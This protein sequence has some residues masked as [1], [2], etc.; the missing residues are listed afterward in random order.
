[1]D[2]AF[3]LSAFEGPLDLLL[4]LIEQNK[5][6][7]YDIPISMITDQY[8][9]YLAEMDKHDAEVT[10][11]FLV[12]AATLLD[13]KAKMLLP[14]E[15]DAEGNEE[16][17]RAELV[18]KLI[19]YKMYK[20]MSVEL[21]D[22]AITA[23]KAMFKGATIPEDVAQYEPPIDLDVFVGNVTIEKLKA[24]FDDVVKRNSEL[25]NVEAMR[26]GRI[27]REA[28]SIPDKI[29]ELREFIGNHKQFSFREFI[30]RQ[31]TKMNIIVSF[32]AILELMKTGEIWAEQDG[33]DNDI[34]LYT[35]H[36]EEKIGN[37]QDESDN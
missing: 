11:E 13:I 26:Y 9:E 30:E 7:I 36:L 34:I 5:V 17:P 21:K 1:M 6:D 32:L 10:S 3:K 24:V 8:L 37:E 18:Q 20:Y 14:K 4:H 15:V 33:N 2:I 12:M 35:E 23:S 22:K 19:E 27:Q 29:S 16:D 25:V 28:I 31:L